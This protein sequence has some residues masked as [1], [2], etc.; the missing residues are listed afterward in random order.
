MQ[1]PTAARSA[2]RKLPKYLVM[3]SPVLKAKSDPIRL[4]VNVAPNEN[5][6]S[7]FRNHRAS[8][9]LWATMSGSDP[10]PKMNRPRKKAGMLRACQTITAPARTRMEKRRLAFRVPSLSVSIPP[11]STARTAATLY[12]VKKDPTVPRAACNS[13]TSVG[14]MAPTMS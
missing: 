7:L 2:Y 8:M 5:A 14:A 10:A 4:T 11:I 12:M 6:S 1:A 9:A 13:S 3:S